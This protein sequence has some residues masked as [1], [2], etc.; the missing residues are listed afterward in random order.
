MSSPDSPGHE[1]SLPAAAGAAP[2][3]P[4]PKELVKSRQFATLLLIGAIVGVPVA[5]VAYFILEL[6]AE[7]QKFL[8]MTLPGNLGFDSAPVWWPLPVLAL[9]GVLVA[10]SLE[11]LPGTGGHKPA[12]GF[13]AGGQVMPVDLPGVVLAA[14]GTLCFGFVLGPEA[15]LIAIGSGMGVIAMRLIRRDAPAMATVVIAAAGSFAA[16]STLLGSPLASAFLLMEA[17]AAPAGMMTIV[18]L[19]GLLAA[20]I[21]AL[22]FVGLNA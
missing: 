21:G 6:V 17:S 15:P 18:L 11:H 16:I 5:I 20:G 14:L 3:P 4:D 9:G 7:A 1:A 22:I 10:L 12:E 2:A 8:F 19:P 13:K